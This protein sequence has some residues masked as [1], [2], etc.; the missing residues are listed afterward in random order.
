MQSCAF[1]LSLAVRD[2]L[3]M[4][5]LRGGPKPGCILAS[6]EELKKKKKI[7]AHVSRPSSH[8]CQWFWLKY[9]EIVFKAAQGIVLCRQHWNYWTYWSSLLSG[10]CSNPGPTV[11]QARCIGH[12]IQGGKVM[13]AQHTA[14]Q[15][16][17]RPPWPWGTQGTQFETLTL[18][19]L[20]TSTA[21]WLVWPC[22]H[23][24]HALGA[25]LA[26]R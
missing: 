5:K 24:F 22:L 12:K 8:P 4:Y 21:S 3:Q 20:W 25:S 23:R 18:W 11:R 26:S 7:H 2:C 19:V 10:P 13:W 6:P 9:P 17:V 14:L 1:L 15:H 16:P